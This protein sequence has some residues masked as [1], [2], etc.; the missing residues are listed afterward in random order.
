MNTKKDLSDGTS[1]WEYVG[2]DE[3]DKQYQ[4]QKEQEAMSQK[5]RES[6]D[7]K[8]KELEERASIEPQYLFRNQTDLYSEFDNEVYIETFKK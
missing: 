1:E 5:K 2:R 8:L 6:I 7:R 4:W 3:L